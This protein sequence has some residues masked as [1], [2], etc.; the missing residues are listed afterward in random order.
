MKV[1]NIE[2][3]M[4]AQALI[5]MIPFEL[6]RYLPS[7]PPLFESMDAGNGKPP[8][9]FDIA[10]IMNQKRKYFFWVRR[11]LYLCDSLGKETE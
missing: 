6:V 7:P 4:Y 3:V 1:T 10:S 5:N 8:N 2:I 9:V 11:G